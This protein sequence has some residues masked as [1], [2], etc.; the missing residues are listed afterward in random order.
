[1]NALCQN[2]YIHAALGMRT[3]MHVLPSSLTAA[4]TGLYYH[5]L[6]RGH[7]GLVGLARTVNKRHAHWGWIRKEV[8]RA[9]SC[10]HR[11]TPTLGALQICYQRVRGYAA[12]FWLTQPKFPM[13]TRKIYHARIWTQWALLVVRY[14]F[15]LPMDCWLYSWNSPKWDNTICLCFPRSILY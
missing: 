9:P 13:L 1:M 2:V 11:N 12:R 6:W 3:R 10:S 7:D 14:I 4:A 15:H 8:V 5:K